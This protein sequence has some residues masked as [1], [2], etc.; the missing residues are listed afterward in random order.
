M[1]GTSVEI[2]DGSLG[3]L[4]LVAFRWTCLGRLSGSTGDVQLSGTRV[5]FPSCCVAARVHFEP[6]QQRNGSCDQNGYQYRCRIHNHNHLFS[7]CYAPCWWARVL[8]VRTIAETAGR[9]TGRVV[10]ASPSSH[11][12]VNCRTQLPQSQ[13]YS[14]RRRHAP[15]SHP[16]GVEVTPSSNRYN[17]PSRK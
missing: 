9:R 17:L 7:N 1:S 15:V 6:H 12:R 5:S 4:G 10:T 16:A 13:K 2:P 14:M 11:T 8:S 3:C